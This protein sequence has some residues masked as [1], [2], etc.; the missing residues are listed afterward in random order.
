[1]SREDED[2]PEVVSNNA[3]EMEYL[4][5]LHESSAT[6]TTNKQKRK[7]AHIPLKI[8][9]DKALDEDVLAALANIDVP[10]VKKKKAKKAAIVEEDDDGPT[11]SIDIGV[12][13]T[14][15]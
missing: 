2:A 8:A 15:M 10:A 12:R 3:A 4:R 5:S 1:M 9:S 6:A 11:S 14:K 13:S 7:P